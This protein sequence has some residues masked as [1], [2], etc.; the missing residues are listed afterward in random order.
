MLCEKNLKPRILKTIK[1]YSNDQKIKTNHDKAPATVANHYYNYLIS[2]VLS[3]FKD[4]PVNLYRAIVEDT[5]YY[6][7]LQLPVHELID[8]EFIAAFV[9]KGELTLV[10][11]DQNLTTDN[12]I[13]ITPTG[14][15]VLSLLASDYQEL[16]LEGSPSFFSRQRNRFIVKINLK[17]ETF[18][19]GKKKYER[20]KK[21]LENNFKHKFDVI[22]SWDPPEEKVCPS[23]VASWFNNRGHKTFVCHQ[24]SSKKI[25]FSIDPPDGDSENLFSWMDN[26]PN[27][28]NNSS[29]L[30]IKK[31]ILYIEYRGFFTRSRVMKILNTM[32]E[33]LNS[34]KNTE[35]WGLHVRGFDNSPVSW[36]LK[37]HAVINNDGTNNYTVI[38]KH[39]EIIIQKC[40]SSSSRPKNK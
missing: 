22:V 17:E 6:K 1:N 19:A 11:A 37:E 18:V 2:V 5:D 4:I 3:G 34:S 20:V 36:G 30:D 26:L 8:Q 27:S 9:K 21:C 16:G 25:S 24:K 14:Y 15:L 29:E 23:S 32:K 10:S 28:I 39:S 13:C 7:V 12:S 35:F 38:L 40:L 31:D 33:L